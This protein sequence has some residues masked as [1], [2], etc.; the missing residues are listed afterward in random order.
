ML[1]IVCLFLNVKTFAQQ[2]PVTD[3][4]LF[5][6]LTINPAFAGSQ[7]QIS[8]TAIHKDQ[9]VNF[10]GSPVTQLFSAHS[11]FLKSKIGVGFLISADKIGIHT[12]TGIYGQY[13][14][15]IKTDYGTLSMGLQGGF[16]NISSDFNKLDVK[17]ADPSLQGVRNSFNPN[18]GAGLYFQNEAIFAGLSVPYIL[19]SKLDG[20]TLQNVNIISLAQ[21]S[22]YYYLYGGLTFPVNE[23]IKFKPAALIRVQEDA[24]LTFDFNVGFVFYEVMKI[25]AVHRLTD[26]MIYTVELALME[27]LHLGYSYQQTIS[28]IS[29]Y[30]NGSHEIMINYRIKIPKIHEGLKCPSYF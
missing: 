15:K 8:M 24:P 12:D 21:R 9:W 23:Y 20:A 1:S 19:N 13:S 7:V 30:A 6:G 4:Y 14:Y 29:S 28:D 18:F 25:G 10:P 16:N 3:L 17:Y 27:S 22:R 2:Q 26:S 11:G 5:E